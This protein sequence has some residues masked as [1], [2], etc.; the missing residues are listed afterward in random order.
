[1]TK[2][3]THRTPKTYKQNGPR[4]QNYQCSNGHVFRAPYGGAVAP[5][6]K[7]REAAPRQ[8]KKKVRRVPLY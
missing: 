7:C 4:N 2:K 6:P 5:C 8:I 3:E 1:M